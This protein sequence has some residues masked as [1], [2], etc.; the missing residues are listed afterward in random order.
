M[1][2]DFVLRASVDSGAESVA[3]FPPGAT[4]VCH[5]RHQFTQLLLQQADIVVL[6]HDDGIELFN[7]VI[8]KGEAAF[9]F[10]QALDVRA[11]HRQSGQP[12]R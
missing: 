10:I 4:E 7:R 2:R 6:A 1:R 8:E 3:G 5:P 9:Q 12:A 11:V